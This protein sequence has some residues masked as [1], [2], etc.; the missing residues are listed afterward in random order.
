MNVTTIKFTSQELDEETGLYYYRSRFYDPSLGRFLTPDTIVPDCT[1][2]Q[3]FNRY[4]YVLNNP[5]IYTDPTGHFYDPPGV[6]TGDQLH[7]ANAGMLGEEGYAEARA[8]E[9][10]SVITTPSVP[11]LPKWIA[12]PFQ[13]YS[14]AYMFY[15]PA[16]PGQRVDLFGEYDFGGQ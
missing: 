11:Y 8:Q 12:D 16:Y 2:P 9:H 10:G 6:G 1:N 13:W 15:D 3:A 7:A 4:A 14:D 5:I